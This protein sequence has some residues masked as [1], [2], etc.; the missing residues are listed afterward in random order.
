M[1]PLRAEDSRWL[2]RRKMIDERWTKLITEWQPIDKKRKRERQ[3]T[4]WADD[5]I[6]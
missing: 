2:N 5:L 6:I 1:E 3:L 4:R